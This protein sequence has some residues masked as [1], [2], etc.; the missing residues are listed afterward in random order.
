MRAQLNLEMIY[1]IPKKERRP[2]DFHE[3]WSE[4]MHYKKDLQKRKLLCLSI[5]IFWISWNKGL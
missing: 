2:S 5:I 4:E 1:K 3:F